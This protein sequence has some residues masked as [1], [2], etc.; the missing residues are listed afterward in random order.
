MSNSKYCFFHDPSVTEKRKE[1]LVKGGKQRKKQF[2]LEEVEI[3]KVSD[4]LSLLN[5]CI[6]EIRTGKLSP[7]TANAIGYLANI[8]LETLKITEIDKRLKEIENVLKLRE[9]EL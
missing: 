8:A 4:I 3:N 6:N 9:K 2:P 7:K 1:A 5:R